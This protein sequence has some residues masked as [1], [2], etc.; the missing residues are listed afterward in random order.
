MSYSVERREECSDS[1]EISR[2]TKEGTYGY[3]AKV[4]FNGGLITTRRKLRN[5]DKWFRKAY[6]KG[7]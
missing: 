6:I 5:I 4:Y 3:T 2:S 1:I 7:R